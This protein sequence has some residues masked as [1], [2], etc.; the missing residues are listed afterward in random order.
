MD[1]NKLDQDYEQD[2]SR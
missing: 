1:M 2:A